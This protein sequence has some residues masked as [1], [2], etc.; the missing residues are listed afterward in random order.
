MDL[1]EPLRGAMEQMLSWLPE[2]S[3]NTSK[4]F[5]FGLAKIPILAFVAPRVDELTAEQCTV[6]IPLSYRTQNH[7]GCMYYGALCVGAELPAGLLSMSAIE[8]TGERID[9]IFKTVQ[10]QF[11]KR[12]HQDAYFV[13]KDGKLLQEAVEK[14]ASTSERQT[15]S[16]QVQVVVRKESLEEAVASFTFEISFKRKALKR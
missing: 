15:L 5:L 1:P 10:A 14:A 16:T 6:R 2:S 4:L 8:K 7:L 13:C 12:V 9:L 11:I 3:K